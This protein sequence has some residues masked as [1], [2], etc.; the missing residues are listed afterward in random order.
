MLGSMDKSLFAADE[1]YDQFYSQHQFEPF[2]DDLAVSA[3]LV[4]PRV[5]WAMDVAE[6]IDA[7]NVLDL[8]CLDGFASLTL[9][10]HLGLEAWG[11]D[12]SQDGIDLAN[13]RADKWQLPAHYVPGAIESAI[14]HRKFDLVLLFEAIE[15]FTDVDKVMAEIKGHLKPGGTVLITTPD[16]EGV[17]GIGNDDACHLRIYTYRE[18]VG[19]LKS[20]KPLV[21]LPAYIEAQGFEVV[22]CGVFNHLIQ[23]RAVLR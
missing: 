19:E 10:N 4:V 3:H 11:V 2:P 21:S 14:P 8:C 18:S 6:D 22:D 16:A 15:H 1:N 5:G 13:Q 7:R 23:L 9:A 12:L 20:T 17:F